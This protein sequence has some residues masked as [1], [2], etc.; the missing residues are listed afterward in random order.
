MSTEWGLFNDEGCLEAGFWSKAEAVAAIGEHYSAED[1]L[2]AREV[3]PDHEEQARDSCE[4]CDD[5]VDEDEDD[6]ESE[7]DG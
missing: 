1:E 5:D 7:D 6:D 4:E 3:C 2:T